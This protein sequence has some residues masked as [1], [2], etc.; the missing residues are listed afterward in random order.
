MGTNSL[1]ITLVFLALRQWTICAFPFCSQSTFLPSFAPRS[2]Q[3]F[4][5]RMR[6]LTPGCLSLAQRGIP[7]SPHMTFP[8]VLSPTTLAHSISAFSTLV[9]FR[10]LDSL[11]SAVSRLHAS[12]LWASP[13][14]SRL[15]TYQGRIE[16]LSYGPTGSP[17]VALHPV[18]HDAVTVGFQPVERLVERLLTSSSCALSGALAKPS[19]LEPW[20]VL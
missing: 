13:L 2:L 10:V 7:D 17:S 19:R 6:V 18:F 8:V 20:D 1:L 11:C 4:F 3:R 5:A 9:C 16:F 14:A 12:D 15:A